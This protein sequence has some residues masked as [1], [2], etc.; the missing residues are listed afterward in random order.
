MHG[1]RVF[2]STLAAVNLCCHHQVQTQHENSYLKDSACHAKE[3]A[4][5][6]AAA[7]NVIPVR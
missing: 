3:A 5:A 1:I 6:A 2:A 4:A 7:G